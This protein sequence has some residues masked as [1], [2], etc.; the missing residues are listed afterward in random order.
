MREVWTFSQTVFLQSYSAVLLSV[1]WTTWACTSYSR[2][3]SRML[4]KRWLQLLKPL[5]ICSKNRVR[6]SPTPRT[7]EFAVWPNR[8]YWPQIHRRSQ[9]QVLK[10]SV[11]CRSTNFP[12]Q[13]VCL[14]HRSSD[15]QESVQ[16]QLTY[17]WTFQWPKEAK[18][19]TPKPGQSKK[20][21]KSMYDTLTYLVTVIM[22]L[23]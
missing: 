22:E 2:Q 23:W 3:T 20:R 16:W 14:S 9:A 19:G 10:L 1:S 7:W 8:S 18:E 17:V 13:T 4:C 6:I 15:R 5:E 11:F 12:L 21:Q